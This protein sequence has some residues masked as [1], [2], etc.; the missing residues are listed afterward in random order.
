[1]PDRGRTL[2]AKKQRVFGHL[3]LFVLSPKYHR[4]ITVFILIVWR[5]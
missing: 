1:M 3:C 4:N 2:A 5:H